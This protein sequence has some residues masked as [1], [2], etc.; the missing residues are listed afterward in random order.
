MR[1]EVLGDCHIRVTIVTVT[2]L[3]L[4]QADPASRSARPCVDSAFSPG[5]VAHELTHITRGLA[6]QSRRLDLPFDVREATLLKIKCPD[7]N[8]V[9]A[10]Y[11]LRTHDTLTRAVLVEAGL[12]PLP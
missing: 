12:P 3:L 11:R 6:Q 2:L 9:E 5:L 8:V 4:T 10:Q 1:Y 7:C